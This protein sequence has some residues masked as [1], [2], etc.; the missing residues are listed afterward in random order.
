MKRLSPPADAARWWPPDASPDP[1]PGALKALIERADALQVEAFTQ[2]EAIEA[3]VSARAFVIEQAVL[4]AWHEALGDASAAALLAVGGFGRGELHPKSDVD[5]LVLVPG[6][7][8][9]ELIQQIERLFSRLWDEG[10]AIGHAVRSV[11]ECIEVAESEITIATN[12]F[13]ARWIAGAGEPVRELLRALDQPGCWPAQRFRAAK[14][15]EQAARHARFHD[16]AYN[17]EPN[18]KEGPGGL[19]D[20]ATLLWIGGRCVGAPTLEAL[21]SV[22]LLTQAEYDQLRS[23]RSSLWQVRFALHQLS[24][25][26]EERLLF[27]H[28]KRLAETFG[29]SSADDP[30][31]RGVEHFMQRF[32]RALMT[33]DRI[34]ERLLARIDARLSPDPAPWAPLGD[35]FGMRSGT[36]E[37]LGAAVN[38]LQPVLLLRAF[39]LPLDHPE[40]VRFGPGLLGAIERSLPGLH[41]AF[42]QDRAA[43]EGFLAICDHPGAVDQALARMARYGV[44]GQLIPAFAQVTGHM[45]FDLFHV[46][47]VDQHTLFVVR[48]LRRLAHPDSARELRLAHTLALRLKRPALLLLAGLFHDIAKGRGGDHALLG[49]ADA[50][51]FCRALGLSASDADLVAW[52]VRHH[53][54]MSITAQKQD[55]SD[56]A[57]VRRFA[58]ACGDEERLDHLYC[59]TIAD[60][61]ATSP[62]LWNSWRDRLLLELHQAA[63]AALARG[64][65]DPAQRSERVRDAKDAAGRLV[66]EGREAVER[67][68]RDFPDDS[69]LRYTPEQLAW[70][71]RAIVRHD[72]AP[73]PLVLVR[74]ARERGTTEVFV[75][76]AD[77][78]G[79]FATITAVIDRMSLSVVEARVIG[80]RN[81]RTLDTFQVLEANGT[82]VIEPA[83]EGQLVL[84]LRDELTR[85]LL[86]AR[87]ARRVL[88][89]QQKQ[90]SVPAQ[91]SF[92]P[93]DASRTRMRLL[94]ADRPGLLAHVAQAMR[95]A[96][97]AVLDARIATFGE[98]A[99]DWFSLSGA[100]GA[101]EPSEIEALRCALAEQLDFEV[102]LAESAA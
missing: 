77:R 42:A 76:V 80:S 57:V 56:P 89:R 65:V 29:D 39:A 12:C 86:S 30:E 83:R 3:L 45:Q 101:L 21:A 20:F 33:V 43:R 87:P 71:T 8:P 36:L 90:F 22:E 24:R 94:C 48:N 50:Q 69:F 2:G 60:I 6:A 19:R 44:L 99:E 47:T 58:D 15:A 34:G 9:A 35:G 26:A 78:P 38:P 53:L 41:L 59:L 37:W 68:W 51:E 91:I 1:A 92:E 4:A 11:A 72:G 96:R 79:V 54:L 55:I 62:K 16:T 27:E 93:I 18:L 70:Q 14:L 88:S 81:A 46:Y 98:R 61:R 13:E 82:P 17:L 100:R 97:I 5:L 49:A 23:A 40:M 73:E 63:R 31:N 32:F 66:G 67:V 95:E 7:R 74:H 52:L 85:E 75:H 10:L 64:E 28:Q 25:R 84:R 102:T